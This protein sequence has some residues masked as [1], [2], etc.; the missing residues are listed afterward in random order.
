MR[1]QIYQIKY[2]ITEIKMHCVNLPATRHRRNSQHRKA[3]LALAWGSRLKGR[4]Q[5]EEWPSGEEEDKA[6]RLG[7][8]LPNKG[9][10]QK[11]RCCSGKEQQ[12]AAL[13]QAVY[14]QGQGRKQG[15][16]ASRFPAEALATS[17]IF[18]QALVLGGV[19]RKQPEN[20]TSPLVLLPA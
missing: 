17:A 7:F 9:Q 15:S 4:R 8:V 6:R 12:R 18:L 19:C 11:T 3:P 2:N 14:W 13:P 16:L 1:S 20:G 10:K 5:K